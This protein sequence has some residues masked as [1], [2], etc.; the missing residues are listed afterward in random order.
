M[1]IT[2]DVDPN[3]SAFRTPTIADIVAATGCSEQVAEAMLEHFI[4]LPGARPQSTED[5]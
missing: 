2:V 3:F 4:V 1:P 5:A